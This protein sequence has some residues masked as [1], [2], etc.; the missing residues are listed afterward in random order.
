MCMELG[1]RQHQ[2]KYVIFV[3]ETLFKSLLAAFLHFYMYV[4]VLVLVITVTVDSQG[5]YLL[6]TV[7]NLVKHLAQN[8]FV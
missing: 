8:K 2:N 5:Q 1:I 7:T 3:W 6:S 4:A